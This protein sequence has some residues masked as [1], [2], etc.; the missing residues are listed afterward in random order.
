MQCSGK[1]VF[2]VLRW[3]TVT[4]GLQQRPCTRVPART[5]C[6]APLRRLV[7][8][9]R[10]YSR[11]F[12]SDT[13]DVIPGQIK[14]SLLNTVVPDKKISTVAYNEPAPVEVEE[15][16]LPPI[17]SPSWEFLLPLLK[18]QSEDDP[19]LAQTL[20]AINN[21]LLDT[22]WERDII[23]NDQNIMSNLKPLGINK[24]A[25]VRLQA[26]QLLSICGVVSPCKGNGVRLLAID[27]GGTRGI[28]AIS[29]LKRLEALTGL[30]AHEM[31]DYCIG[32]STGALLISMAIAKQR[33]LD[34]VLDMYIKL[35]EEVFGGRS[36]LAMGRFFWKQHRYASSAWEKVLK[37][38]CNGWRMSS[39]GSW[40]SAPQIAFVSTVVNHEV[41]HPYVFR[42]YGTPDNTPLHRG[43]F[44][45]YV[46]EG[47]RATTAAPGYFRD[48]HLGSDIHVD[49]ALLYNNPTALGIHEVKKLWP[50]EKIQCVVSIGTGQLPWS[51]QNKAIS[52]YQGLK[53][54]LYNVIQSCVE[55][56][57]THHTLNELLPREI[58]YRF[59]P[60]IKEITP[61]DEIN[62]DVLKKLQKQTHHFLSEKKERLDMCAKQITEDRSRLNNFWDNVKF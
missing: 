32:T 40:D 30:R 56:E 10:T 55:T 18:A 12:T 25:K 15:Q 6:N 9:S 11:S 14:Q 19:D 41:V 44:S 57:S 1:Q 43:C 4:V 26:K 48:M 24:D 58:Y 28:I 62:Q 7:I 21:K 22:T 47:L 37:D 59:N 45:H 53:D 42:S 29:V 46:W 34:E 54:N 49:G 52:N 51:Y 31:F 2:L 61:L 20:K 16:E 39:V 5:F 3:S 60:M 8:V 23:K 36:V 27:G 35:S 17:P 33:P 38:E 13:S 50:K